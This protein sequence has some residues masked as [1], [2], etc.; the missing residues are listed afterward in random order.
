MQLSGWIPASDV[1]VATGGAKDD[2]GMQSNAAIT[3]V[4]AT[5]NNIHCQV[6]GPSGQRAYVNIA[7]PVDVNTTAIKVFVNGTKLNPPP[8][9]QIST[10]G[11]HYLVYLE[12]MLSA[13]SVE[14]EFGTSNWI[15]DFAPYIAIIFVIIIVVTIVGIIH[16]KRK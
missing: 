10:N 13:H 14:I 11:T 7:V 1:I 8:F 9:P 3:D 12:L 4:V 6:S 16:R 5:K 2:F 15:F